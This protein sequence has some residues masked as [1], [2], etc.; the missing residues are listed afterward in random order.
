MNRPAACSRRATSP[1]SAFTL[2]ELLVVVSIIAILAALLLPALG[3]ARRMAIRSTCAAQ[4]KQLLLGTQMYVDESEGFVPTPRDSS[5]DPNSFDITSKA[6]NN[7][8]Y[9]IALGSVHAAGFIA[10]P[11]VLY[12]PSSLGSWYSPAQF[13]NSKTWFTGTAP[14]YLRNSY[15]YRLGK[16]NLCCG[17]GFG[18]K[19]ENWASKAVAADLTHWVESGNGPGGTITPYLHAQG[20]SLNPLIG[21][22]DGMNMVFQDGHVRWLDYN[23]LLGAIGKSACGSAVTLN[24]ARVSTQFW[25]WADT[26]F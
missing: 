8:W 22:R 7:L 14:S 20:Y 5:T 24:N 3:K 18:V 9:P 26:Q 10:D 16:T 19:W 2:I 6:A 1:R 13:A 15:A 21:T 25:C 4:Q 23:T 12:C 17:R 11:R